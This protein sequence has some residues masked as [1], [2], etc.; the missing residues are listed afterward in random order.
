MS[1]DPNQTGGP[2]RNRVATGED[3]EVQ[4]FVDNI[5]KQR[6]GASTQAIRAALDAA[7]QDSG[8]SSRDV[9]TQKVLSIIAAR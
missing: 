4:D 2:D 1:D 9:L 7:R 5:K 6:P 8:S 3:Y